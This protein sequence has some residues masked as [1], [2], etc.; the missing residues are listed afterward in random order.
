MGQCYRTYHYI[1]LQCHGFN[2]S[3]ALALLS[4][5][6]P[7]PR[8]RLALTLAL[9]LTLILA[10]P[11]SLEVLNLSCNDI[12]NSGVSALSR[13]MEDNF[14]IRELSLHDN[15]FTGRG[16]IALAATLMNTKTLCN[17]DCAGNGL[18]DPAAVSVSTIR[19]Y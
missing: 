13:G 5:P 17:L 11:P 19:T 3:L 14:T 2:L 7:R 6:R 16:F 15:S 8:L 12:N 4:P 1:K 18:A 9:A 10:R